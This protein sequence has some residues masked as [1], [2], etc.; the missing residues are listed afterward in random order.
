MVGVAAIGGAQIAIS[1]SQ[2]AISSSQLLH[3]PAPTSAH[4]YMCSLVPSYMYTG[5]VLELAYQKDPLHLKSFLVNHEVKN[6]YD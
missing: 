6:E 1:S 2:L 4:S 5:I 3:M